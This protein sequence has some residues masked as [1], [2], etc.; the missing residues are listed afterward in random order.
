M[1]RTVHVVDDDSLFRAAMGRLLGAVGY[2]VVSYQS[3]TEFLE[4]LPGDGGP[5]VIL[6]DLKMSGLT[7]TE[8]Q[9]ALIAAGSTVP[10]VFISGC[11]DIRTSVRAI[12][13]GAED[14]LTKPVSKAD[15]IASIER[16]IAR[17]AAVKEQQQKTD[18]LQSLIAKLTP[19]ER[20]VFELLVKGKMN[21]QIAFDLGTTERTIKAHRQKVMT[22]IGARSLRELVV[23][24]EQFKA[25]TN[26]RGSNRE[27]P[28]PPFAK[29]H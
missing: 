26:L 3:A 21:K 12:K 2:N 1:S 15:L 27:V 8:L 14:F 17:H 16:A 11:A 13:A 5:T 10:I 29:C 22:K 9:N 25:L 23:I 6:L 7:G 20:Q 19:R 28:R 18:S 4:R 24:A